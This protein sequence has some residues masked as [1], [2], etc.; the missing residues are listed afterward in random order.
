M[1]DG[2]VADKED[3]LTRHILELPSS[4]PRIRAQTC[5]HAAF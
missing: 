4:Y 2:D 5:L 3:A 1:R